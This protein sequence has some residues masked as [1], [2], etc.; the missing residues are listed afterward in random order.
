MLRMSHTFLLMVTR[1]S[2][3]N[4]TKSK[5]SNGAWPKTLTSTSILPCIV[6]PDT[7][8]SFRLIC[9]KTRLQARPTL[10]SRSYHRNTY[11]M[12][13]AVASSRPATGSASRSRESMT[14]RCITAFQVVRATRSGMVNSPRRP[15]AAPVGFRVSGCRAPAAAAAAAAVP[16]GFCR[17]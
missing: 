10:L 8:K 3:T 13:C 7:T 16:S 14:K 17:V 6:K 9:C 4:D 15:M 2:M 1:Q 5:V 12:L 11:N